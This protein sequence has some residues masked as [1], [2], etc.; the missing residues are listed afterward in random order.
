MY[1]DYRQSGDWSSMELVVRS[2][3]DPQ[4]LAAD[5]RK[6]LAAYNPA[7]PSGEFYPLTRLVDDAVA[8]RRLIT[9][10]ARRLLDHGADP[11]RARPLRRH[12]LRGHPADAGDRRAD[13]HRRPAPGDVLGLVVGG[14]LRLVGV[15]IGV[16]LEQAPRS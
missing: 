7:L 11:G 6:A 12:L 5:V 3:R 9:G 10:N 1:L 13:R 2:A 4:S 14:G 16:G 15:G 8:P